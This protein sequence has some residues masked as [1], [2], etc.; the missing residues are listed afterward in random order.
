MIGRNRNLMD[1]IGQM[2]WYA[3]PLNIRV[4]DNGQL[5]LARAEI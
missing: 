4:L 2:W 3:S 1:G 5:R